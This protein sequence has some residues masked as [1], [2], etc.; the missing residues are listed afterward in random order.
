MQGWWDRWCQRLGSFAPGSGCGCGESHWEKRTWA[1]WKPICQGATLVISPFLGK[2]LN[3]TCRKYIWRCFSWSRLDSKCIQCLAY[4]VSFLLP[5]VIWDLSEEKPLYRVFE[6]KL[7]MQ[8]SNGWE[9]LTVV[10]RA[11]LKLL[12]SGHCERACR[13]ESSWWSACR[14]R[15]LTA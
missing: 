6:E 9:S 4:T 11:S 3:A 7:S 10:V 14:I 15:C 1:P 2:P 8:T 5:D 12:G 13:R